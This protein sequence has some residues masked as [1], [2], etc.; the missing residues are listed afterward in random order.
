MD[1]ACIRLFCLM[2]QT[3]LYFSNISASHFCFIT[4]YVRLIYSTSHVVQYGI[5]VS[6]EYFVEATAHR[7]ETELSRHSDL[8]KPVTGKRCSHICMLYI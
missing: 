6:E 8:T 2:G 4:S 5:T 1:E 7:L 3:A